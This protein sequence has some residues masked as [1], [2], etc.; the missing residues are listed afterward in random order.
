M[1]FK[2]RA[3]GQTGT[4]KELEAKHPIRFLGYLG[5]EVKYT[6]EKGLYSALENFWIMAK[7]A[8][9]ARD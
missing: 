5:A 1:S 8:I 9:G 4:A 7:I 2:D 3:Y 6:P